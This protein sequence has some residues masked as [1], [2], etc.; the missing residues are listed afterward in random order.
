MGRQKRRMRPDWPVKVYRYR[1]RDDPAAQPLW[2]SWLPEPVYAE[3]VAMRQLWNGLCDVWEHSRQAWDAVYEPY[4]SVR[5]A[6]EALTAA[7][8][9][10]QQATKERALERQ[11]RR[12]RKHEALRPL[13]EAVQAAE[14][15]RRIASARLREAKA[16]IGAETKAAREAVQLQLQRDLYAT[17]QK[18]PLY[19][20]HKGFI[21]DEF[22][23]ALGRF[24][25]RQAEPPKRHIGGLRTVH[26]RHHFGDG[27]LPVPA[28]WRPC[29][30][31][32]LRPPDPRS[33]EETKY[34]PRAR[35]R[36]AKSHGIYRV[37]GRWP[38]PLTLTWLP[39]LPAE[40]YVKKLD[41]VGRLVA[42]AGW[43]SNQMMPGVWEPTR[44]RGMGAE[45]G[46]VWEWEL[47]VAVEVPPPERVRRQDHT[48]AGVDLGWR[49]FEQPDGSR[50]LRMGVVLDQDGR[51]E[52]LWFP[53][54]VLAR[55]Q[56]ARDLQR[57]QGEWT[58]DTRRTLQRI[59]GLPVS[60]AS[61]DRMG[62]AG[63]WRLHR[64][65]LTHPDAW[66]E[67]AREYLARWATAT[68]T[69]YQRMRRLIVRAIRERTD[70]FRKMAWRL[71]QQYA[72]LAFEDL[73]M[74]ELEAADRQEGAL[75]GAA[76][77]RQ[78]VAPYAFRQAVQLVAP[79]AGTLVSWRDPAYTTV[80]C[81][82]CTARVLANS[83]ALV[84]TCPAG[85]SWDQD[86]NAARNLVARLNG[87]REDRGCAA[88]PRH[89][90]DVEI[91]E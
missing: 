15:C 46:G 3:A 4:G 24:F 71:C 57:R 29:S 87:G 13:D 77:Y 67:D 28:I 40:G 12:S 9:A 60:A 58:E 83:G 10:L 91:P 37:A 65:A 66:P 62:A 55:W 2:M 89:A 51:A 20:A 44:R 7:T 54:G 25:R 6:R 18:A 31:Y 14:A 72:Q 48:R 34:T 74:A 52:D 16:A 64:Q 11:R 43:S 30:R 86:E 76:K 45:V 63:L 8:E 32:H 79:K 21:L 59:E 38:L 33:A 61:L 17:A 84:L 53:D 19:W 26:F 50:R 70:A 82:V 1:V 85:H 80:D 5:E 69:C 81:A 88:T 22:R 73:G 27:G 35:R 49:V 39:P 56:R 36:F 78:L 42:K 68:T 23:A 41:L 75:K 90:R 47:H